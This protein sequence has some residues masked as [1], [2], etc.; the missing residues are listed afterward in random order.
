ME[1]HPVAV[2]EQLHLHQQAALGRDENFIVAT[3]TGSGKTESFL[4]PLIDDIL[5]TKNDTAGV[6]AILVIH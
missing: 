1:K 4:F 6:K 5:R 3:G 2:A